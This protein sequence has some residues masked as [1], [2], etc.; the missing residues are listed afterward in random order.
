MKGILVNYEKHDKRKMNYKEVFIELLN[1][2]HKDKNDGMISAM[3]AEGLLEFDKTRITS[4]WVAYHI[5]RTT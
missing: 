4:A 2:I 1:Q 5:A 3:I